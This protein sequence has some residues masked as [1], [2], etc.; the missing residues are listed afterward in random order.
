MGEGGIV[1]LAEAVFLVLA[2][3]AG[4]FFLGEARVGPAAL[5]SL[6]PVRSRVAAGGCLFLELFL[7][8]FL[9]LWLF[10]RCCLFAG[11]G[12]LRGGRDELEHIGRA[13]PVGGV[14]EA[15]PKCE[16]TSVAS[17]F[18]KVIEAWMACWRSKATLWVA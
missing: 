8:L 17:C 5:S 13:F 10:P 15:F 7:V 6:S 3:G 2:G 4:A 16:L 9:L 1:F 18:W 14:V 11:A 12:S